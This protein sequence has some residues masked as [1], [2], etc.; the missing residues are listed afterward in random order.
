MRRIILTSVV[1][2]SAVVAMAAHS[3]TMPGG[4]SAAAPVDKLCGVSIFVTPGS[5]PDTPAVDVYP[6]T[7]VVCAV[8]AKVVFS[9]WNYTDADQTV[10]LVDFTHKAT[11][12]RL[13]PRDKPAAHPMVKRQDFSI[14]RDKLRV[15]A[16]FNCTASNQSDCGEYKYTIV[17]GK[18][19]LDPGLQITPP[20]GAPAPA[21]TIHP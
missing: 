10:Q 2:V 21:A 19:I 17:V 11:G 8:G 7:P 9:L 20:N 13:E 3:A 18:T 5:A 12:R 15:D 6:T 1:A 4:Q 14:R 16:A